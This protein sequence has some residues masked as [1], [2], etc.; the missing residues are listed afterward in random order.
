M[1]AE[2]DVLPSYPARKTVKVEENTEKYFN[3]F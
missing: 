3:T 1:E 2:I